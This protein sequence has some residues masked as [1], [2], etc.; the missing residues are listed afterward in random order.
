MSASFQQPFQGILYVDKKT[1]G[2]RR[3]MV[4]SA[5]SKLYSYDAAS[6]QRL[7]VWPADSELRNE[8]SQPASDP[9][10]P[11]EKKR[12]ISE[13]KDVDAVSVTWSNIPLLISSSN[14]EY[15]IALTAEDK[16]IRVFRVED[17]GTLR[18]LSARSMP[19]RP[20]AIAL[21]SD[22]STVLCGDKFG[23][24]YALPLL[25][26][27]NET[28]GFSR[29][30]EKKA[31]QPAATN[32]TV[33]TRRNLEALEQQMR[34]TNVQGSKENSGATFEHAIVL[35][36]VS[37]LTDLALVSLSSPARSYILTA[38]RDEHI[39][40][41][42]GPPQAYVI[43]N[44]CLGHTSF[45]SKLCVLPWASE[46][47]VSGGGDSYLLVWKWAE[48]KLLQKV[49]LPEE[50]TGHSEVA[51][52]GIWSASFKASA[53][54]SDNVNAVLVAI[55]GS[56]KL[57]CYVV[58]PDNTMRHQADIQLTGNALSLATVE[59]QGTIIVSVDGIREPGSFQ[60]WRTDSTS[61]QI[62]LESFKV[63][64]TQGNL[65]WEPLATPM[66][67]AVNSTGTTVLAAL[68][69]KQQKELNDSLYSV[70]NLRKRSHADDE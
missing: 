47:L 10:G 7:A 58:E 4:A 50:I 26:G 36:H 6:G 59:S 63:Q 14:G 9:Q 16:C 51:V 52:R 57:L 32:L 13:A 24:V 66:T 41:S 38:D 67:T 30:L 31:Y 61:P 49:S 18:H 40:V 45:I 37:M 53:D 65:S 33:H 64:T 56:S 43:E 3:L 62:L 1:A 15:V 11:P 54:A 5:G 8:E 29:H 22:D 20:C 25:P 42:R 60:D 68:E 69:P 55:E 27:E 46:I 28:I 12:K 17:D 70:G 44:Y 35:G 34:L 2:S 21:T 23:D 19:K 48:G 39:R